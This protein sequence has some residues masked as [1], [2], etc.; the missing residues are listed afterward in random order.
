MTV[1]EAMERANIKETTLA[2]AW[3]KD[4]IHQIQSSTKEKIKS[5]KQD[6]IK[7]V[8]S[9]DNVYILPGD[10]ISLNS[11]SIKD[12]SDNKYKKIRRLTHQ[13]EYLIED[14]AP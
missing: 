10:M 3:I 12:T 6:V 8:D 13:P 1:L 5:S 14:T 2:I 4:A 9:D 11:V 7:S